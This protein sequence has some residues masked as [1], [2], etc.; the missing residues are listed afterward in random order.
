MNH[1]H[2]HLTPLA[3]SDSRS[4]DSA[5]P[6]D[7]TVVVPIERRQYTRTKLDAW[8]AGSSETTFFSGRT[9]D[10]CPGGV[11][12]ATVS[13]PAIG[14]HVRLRVQAERHHYLVVEV[15]GRVAWHRIEESGEMVG[16]GIAFESP[17]P[18]TQYLLQLMARDGDRTPQVPAH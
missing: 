16:C 5:Y 17:D 14:E 3:E 7:T 10:I 13:P 6:V 15:E 8:V 11:F 4:N 1:A 18:V 2:C 12:I 9:R